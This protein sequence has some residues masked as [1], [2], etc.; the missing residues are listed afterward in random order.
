M[1][2]EQSRAAR[3]AIADG[4][5]SAVAVAQLSQGAL[6][7]RMGHVMQQLRASLED[8]YS[9]QVGLEHTLQS[10]HARPRSEHRST[11]DS[12][13]SSD[14][15]AALERDSTGTALAAPPATHHLPAASDDEAAASGLDVERVLAELRTQVAEAA[16]SGADAH[17]ASQ[18]ISND[19]AT[20]DELQQQ[21][22]ATVAGTL[23][24]LCQQV[25]GLQQRAERTAAE[26]AGVASA[27]EVSGAAS[28]QAL[29][30]VQQRCA[31]AE[32][33][34]IELNGGVA[35]LRKQAA[36]VEPLLRKLHQEPRSEQ[37]T[38]VGSPASGEEVP[39]P[40]S[41]LT[42]AV[43]A[44]ALQ[45]AAQQRSISALQESVAATAAQVQTLDSALA[46]THAAAHPVPPHAS[47]PLPQC[48]DHAEGRR[49]SSA[50]APTQLA[51]GEQASI[52]AEAL[53]N[54][55]DTMRAALDTLERQIVR[56]AA[57]NS[58]GSRL[59]EQQSQRQLH[60][61]RHGSET[62]TLAFI[63]TTARISISNVEHN[64]LSVYTNRVCGVFAT[65]RR[66]VQR[67]WSHRSFLGSCVKS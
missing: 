62:G 10:M 37:A 60:V 11:A 43:D 5:T 36:H 24:V 29:A 63:V 52:D 25:A 28:T 16:Q 50:A 41:H 2:A 31:V 14:Q 53:H 23:N 51:D 58:P 27:A 42:S 6:E 46:S 4:A 21:R 45:L 20:Q 66:C 54:R 56:S 39:T 18:R 59:T 47:P 55:L 64:C 44:V 19:A 9:L 38:I 57:S 48:A 32:R 22:D 1:R 7:A 12:I 65:H 17:A 3:T 15:P 67:R 49:S 40:S 8:L 13:S 33:Q 61:A 26:L 30:A 35:Q 34:V